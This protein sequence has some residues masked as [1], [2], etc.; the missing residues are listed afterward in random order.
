M[1]NNE[2]IITEVDKPWEKKFGKG[3]YIPKDK[4]VKKFSANINLLKRKEPNENEI[5]YPYNTSKIDFDML[6]RYNINPEDLNIHEDKDE[7]NVE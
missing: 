3:I 1:Y 2:D 6:D 5:T 4:Q 7:Y